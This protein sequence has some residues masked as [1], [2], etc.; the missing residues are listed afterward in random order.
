MVRGGA[1]V[2]GRAVEL[3]RP[4]DAGVDAVFGDGIDPEPRPGGEPPPAPLKGQTNP[5]RV[6]YGPK[7]VK[8]L[9]SIHRD[10]E[11]KWVNLE[12]NA[13]NATRVITTSYFNTPLGS[14]ARS[15]MSTM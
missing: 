14:P 15:I 11:A 7:Y 8:Y 2:P 9:Q 6:N 3:P 5:G 10:D 12:N 13:Q 4:P 1:A